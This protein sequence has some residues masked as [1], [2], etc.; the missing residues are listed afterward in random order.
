MSLLLVTSNFKA[1]NRKE[2]LSLD[3]IIIG[4]VQADKRNEDLSLDELTI[5]H[6]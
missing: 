6:F 2:V 1:D 3:E 4:Y 5:G